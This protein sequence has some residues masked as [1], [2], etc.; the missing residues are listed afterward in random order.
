MST[1]K[2]V[3]EP[4]AGKPHARIDAAAG[5]NQRQSGSHSRA[6]WAPPADPTAL[7]LL[8]SFIKYLERLGVERVTTELALAWATEPRDA[9][10]YWWSKR[11]SVVRV[12]ARYL[13]TL[14]ERTEIPPTDLLAPHTRRREPYL[15]SPAQI[16]AL[17]QAAGRL[18]CSLRAATFQALIGLMASTG[19]RTGEAMALDREDVDLR[20]RVLIVPGSKFGKSRLVALHRSA[21]AA[22]EGYARRRD[23]L[24]PH[25]GSASFLLSGAGTRLNHPN[26]STT[27]ARLLDDAGIA[28]PP[29]RARPRLY[30]LRHTFAVTLVGWYAAGVDVAARLPALSTYLGHVKPASTYYYL[31]ATPELMAQAAARL[32]HHYKETP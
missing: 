23:R 15:Y 6:A 18:R 17:M 26:A 24:C 20:E 4:C 22:L 10:P 7:R 1:V 19:L 13:A 8:Q 9:D 3:G 5:G 29:G 14:D 27:F 21:V 30:D 31:H 12:F 28:T 32:E 2:N 16:L 11:L 25:P